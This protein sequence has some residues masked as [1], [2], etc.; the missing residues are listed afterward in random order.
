MAQL[1]YLL[2][3][4]F[5]VIVMV[6]LVK[7]VMKGEKTEVEFEDDLLYDPET[8]SKITLEQAES[9][10]WLVKDEGHDRIVPE[11]EI[12][13]NYPE[14]RKEWR[15]IQNLLIENGY[16]S[17]DFTH[18]G[19]AKLRQLVILRNYSE[20]HFGMPYVGP[21]GTAIFELD[22]R[23][24]IGR[25]KTNNQMLMAN[26][27]LEDD[28]GHY[29]FTPKTVADRLY[30]FVEDDDF[31]F[32]EGYETHQVSATE[33]VLKLNRLLKIFGTTEAV[34]EIEIDKDEIFLKH[35]RLPN[36]ADTK[37]IISVLEKL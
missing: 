34:F 29:V 35:S 32:I 13:A 26:K 7:S 4:V 8:N 18:E 36:V 5:I 3:V 31:V 9:G 22:V 37:C 1:I 20:R 21:E 6:Y 25:Q 24:T 10:I 15:R 14:Y 12:E 16:M 23:E 2:L 11:S 28:F 19:E 17:Q 33:N 27:Q 30:D